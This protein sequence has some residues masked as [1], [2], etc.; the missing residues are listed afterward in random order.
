MRCG[1]VS[2]PGVTVKGDGF[3]IDEPIVRMQDLFNKKAFPEPVGEIPMP[4][5]GTLR[6]SVMGKSGLPVKCE[7]GNT[8]Y[9][10]NGTRSRAIRTPMGT[11]NLPAPMRVKCASCGRT[12]VPPIDIRGFEAYQSKTFGL[13]K[14]ALEKCVQT[15]F[16]RVERDFALQ[17]RR[18]SDSWY[19]IGI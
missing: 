11:V 1:I 13:E 9:V 7:C 5:D 8:D 3:S 4:F 19:C 16:R 17:K 6:L 10:L 12:R 18:I 2:K 14:L 15:S